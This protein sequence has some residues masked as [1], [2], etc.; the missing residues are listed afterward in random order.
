MKKKVI[1]SLLTLVSSQVFAVEANTT[2]QANSIINPSCVMKA[3]DMNFGVAISA[4]NLTDTVGNTV[5]SLRCTKATPYVATINN[6]FG[7]SSQRV[8]KG[9]NPLNQEVLKYRL[10]FGGRTEIPIVNTFANTTG[11]GEEVVTAFSGK[12]I[13]SQF[14]SPDVYYDMLTFTITY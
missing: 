2:I 9:Q 14:V 10:Y 12:V 13:A 6:G 11:T 8:M 5:V 7:S 1:L 3:T 4:A